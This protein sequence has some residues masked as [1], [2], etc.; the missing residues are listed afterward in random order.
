MLKDKD[1]IEISYSGRI[2]ETNHLF[3]TTDENVAKKENVFNQ[4]F[5]YG[6]RIIC[7]GEKQILPKIDIFLIGKE[8]GKEYVLEINPEE[9]FGLKDKNLIKIVNTND[10]KKQRINPF[11]GLQL[12]ASGITGTIRSVNGG[13]TTIDF[14]HPLA[15]KNLVYNIRVNKI[16]TE[17]KIQAECVLGSFLGLKQNE[18]ELKIENKKIEVK[19]KKM[20]NEKIQAEFKEKVKKILP[21]LELSA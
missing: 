2:K 15:G 19:L 12:N 1:F 16:I 17:K 10:L 5:V 21:E 14:N 3:D 6:P 11:P 18:Y 7:L 4:E 9:A 8:I 20:I 13:R